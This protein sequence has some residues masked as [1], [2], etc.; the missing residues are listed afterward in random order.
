MANWVDI[1]ETRAFPPGS[2]VCADAGGTS[3]V[4][5]NIDGELRVIA[6][7]CPHAHMPLGMGERRGHV[8]TCPF[9]GYAYD[10]RTG[11]NIDDPDDAPAR[12]YPVRE[13][14]GRV[15]VDVEP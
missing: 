15:L 11:R 12:T 4:V 3:L 8:I 2:Q 1:G 5:F 13:E 6:N 14:N 10:I 7:S 9:H